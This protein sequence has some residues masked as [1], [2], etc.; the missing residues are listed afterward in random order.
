MRSNIFNSTLGL[1]YGSVNDPL[2]AGKFFLIDSA[3]KLFR[4]GP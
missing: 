4:L 3:S 1:V 2:R